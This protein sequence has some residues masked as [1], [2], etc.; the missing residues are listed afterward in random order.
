VSRRGGVWSVMVNQQYFLWECV[1]R[2]TSVT[3]SVFTEH[4]TH[5]DVDG[6][7][8]LSKVKHETMYINSHTD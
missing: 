5:G 7:D 1:Q 4:T 6:R 8:E 2:L 3:P